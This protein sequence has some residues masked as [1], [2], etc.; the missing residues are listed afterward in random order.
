MAWA[1]DTLAATNVPVPHKA[2]F[3]GMALQVAKG[4]ARD[5]PT[6]LMPVHEDVDVNPDQNIQFFQYHDGRYSGPRHFFVGGYTVPGTLRLPIYPAMMIS[7]GNAGGYEDPAATP[8]V[9]ADDRSDIG[10]WAFQRTAEANGIQG[11]WAT[12]F[13][14]A[15]HARKKIADVKVLSGQIMAQYGQMLILELSVLGAA[16]P[17]DWTPSLGSTDYIGDDLDPYTYQHCAIALEHEGQTLHTADRSTQDHTLSFDNMV[18]SPDEAGTLAGQLPPLYLPNGEAATW[19]G[20][21]SRHFFNSLVYEAFLQRKTV[22]YT[23]TATS[24]DPANILTINMPR[25]LYTAAP[26]RIAN[27]GFVRQ[28]GITFQALAGVD[29][30]GNNVPAFSVSE[31]GTV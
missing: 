9:P 25:C 29:G 11:L 21:F 12:L 28:E 24:T 26:L 23:L 14:D 17:V 31:T 27:T 18:A 30:A 1:P 2:C 16:V 7:A 13:L 3:L 8:V 5:Q 19:T 22:D 15:V 10:R 20:T 4:T 6:I